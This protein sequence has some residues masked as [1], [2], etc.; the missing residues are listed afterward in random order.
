MGYDLVLKDQSRVCLLNIY[1]YSKG[2]S[3]YEVD[4]VKYQNL[5]SAYNHILSSYEK[6]FP[7]LLEQIHVLSHELRL[8]VK[9]VPD[10]EGMP[11]VVDGVP[12]SSNEKGSALDEATRFQAKRIFRVLAKKHHPDHGGDPEVFARLRA[13]MHS[14]DLLALRH[15]LQIDLFDSDL[16]HKSQP[17]SR[18]FW[19][20]CR[21]EIKGRIIHFS[22]TEAY[23]IIRSHMSRNT[24]KAQHGMELL[25]RKR[26]ILLNQEILHYSTRSDVESTKA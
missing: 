12:Q 16:F 24:K 7:S 13:S 20:D 6:M 1:L 3:S 2:K 4:Y 25:L 14:G 17:K 26:I 10:V 21:E 15:R 9:G 11:S 18:E 8:L 23:K 19:L 5:R 22:G